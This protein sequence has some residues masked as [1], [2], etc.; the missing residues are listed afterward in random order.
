MAVE[1]RPAEAG[2]LVRIVE[3][4]A[5]QTCCKRLWGA[6]PSNMRKKKK[7]KQNGNTRAEVKWF[8]SNKVCLKVL[9]RASQSPDLEQPRICVENCWSA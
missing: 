8:S 1:V 9:K 5:G 3:P 4:D 6:S 2:K 7:T